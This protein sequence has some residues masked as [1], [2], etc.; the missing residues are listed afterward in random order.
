MWSFNESAWFPVFVLTAMKSAA[1][2][3][4]AW[5]IAALMRRRSAAARHLV[6][7]AAFAA[8]LALPFLSA[9]MP[10]LHLSQSIPLPDITFQATTGATPAAD[11]AVAQALRTSGVP[12][13]GAPVPRRFDLRFWL[14]AIWAAGSALALLQMLAASLAVA[15]TRRRASHCLDPQAAILADALGL[16]QPV[17]VLKTSPGSM[18]M[19]FGVLRPA[20]LLPSDAAGWT[21]ER[22]RIVLL[23]ELAHV[24]RG[25]VATHLL[26]RIALSLYWWN[27][28]AWTAWRAFLKERERAAD[29]LVLAT[30]ARASDYAGHLL[31][32]ARQ[33]RQSSAIGW[34]AVAMARPSQLEGRLLAILDAGVDRKTPGRRAALIG[35]L[36]AIGVVAPLAALQ[37]QDAVASQSAIDPNAAIRL[38][39][40]QKNHEMLED[41]AKTAILQRQYDTAQK[42][43][44]SAVSIRRQVSGDSSPEYAI[45][46]IKLG[47]LERQRNRLQ[48]AASFYRKAVGILGNQP[49]AAPAYIHLGT[50]AIAQRAFEGA[51]ADFQ[52]AQIADPAKAGPAM[53]WMALTRQR[54]G[55]LAEA[56]SLFRGA[57][58]VEDEKSPA[59]SATMDLYGYL[60]QQ[61]GRK[62]ESALLHNQ[63]Q[64]VRKAARTQIGP[65]DASVYKVGPGVSAPSL[66]YK[67]EPEY[68]EEARAA[69]YQGT[70]TLYVEIGPD[71]LAH[72][73]RVLN[74]L[75][76]GLDE[77]AISAVSAW[78]FKP[79]IK[80][81][82]PVTVAA[83]IEINFRL[84]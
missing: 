82:V 64:E 28:L 20:V 81:G 9:M 21:E 69:K 61:M 2:L 84:L 66:L 35:A 34:A 80:D 24:R 40:A 74:S 12:A 29:D 36:L 77:Q 17:A 4:A 5:L 83:S 1:V 42:L 30:G 31:D 38:A 10:P 57:L 62:D 55:N 48:D 73:A 18:P 25:D 49:E 13:P 56:E 33:M 45:G 63:A 59:A 27:P 65:R 46:L 8:L 71:G 51:V 22:R 54:Q 47:D 26:A 6:W 78:Q 52:Q 7:T 39:L 75:G 11:S 16:R 58:A 70:V 37:G 50:I 53:M 76:L 68:S 3:G 79:G 72:N 19:T 23:H 44:E 43:L 32:V 60:L 41:A 14:M 67:V 15:R